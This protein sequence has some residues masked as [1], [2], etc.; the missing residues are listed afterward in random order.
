MENEELEVIETETTENTINEITYN[1]ECN[2]VDYTENL[3]ALTLQLE[4]LTTTNEQQLVTN[5]FIISSCVGVGV[6][7]I[8]YKILKIFL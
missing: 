8:L 7:L 1:C 3:E 4:Y 6:C 5:I 2:H